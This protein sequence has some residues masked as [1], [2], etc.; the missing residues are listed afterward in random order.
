MTKK[1]YIGNLSYEVSEEDLRELFQQAGKVESLRII[2]DSLTGRSKGFAFVEMME[3]EEA[4]KAIE[5][6]NDHSL[7]ER[8]I[9]VNEA[10]PQRERGRRD[11]GNRGGRDRGR[12]RY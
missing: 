2:T 4:Q 7:K 5:M 9:V 12:S 1:L 10:R 11:F 3:D 8:K 6:F